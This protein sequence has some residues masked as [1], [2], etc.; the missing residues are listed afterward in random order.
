MSI[1]IIENKKTKDKWKPEQHPETQISL[2]AGTDI[3]QMLGVSGKEFQKT[4][5][6]MSWALIAKTYKGLKGWL[7]G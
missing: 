1:K 4:K 6:D 7:L 2:K 3:T 5:T